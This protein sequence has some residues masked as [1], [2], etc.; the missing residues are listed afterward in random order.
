MAITIDR[1][2]GLLVFG[3]LLVPGLL[4]AP[5]GTAS[6]SPGGA[7]LQVSPGRALFERYC[8]TCHGEK[9][10][11]DGPV[12][13]ALINTPSDLTTIA[14]RRGGEFPAAEVARYI[15]GRTQVTAHGTR[16]MPVWGLVFSEGIPEEST[17]EEFVRGK[18]S[19]LVDYLRSI[20][21][22]QRD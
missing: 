17:A 8:V 3:L 12:A 18:I 22:V 13:P 9:G 5:A 14:A 11:G 21:R 4:L 1:V 15:D 19:V 10:R 2:A 16:V 6:T 7:G 20:Q